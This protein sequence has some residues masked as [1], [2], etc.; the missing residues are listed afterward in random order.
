RVQ[1]E[2]FGGVGERVVRDQRSDVREFRLFGAEEFAASGRVEEEVADG[3]GGSGGETSLFDAEDVASG[4]L[5][6]SSG[7]IFGRASFQ[8]KA[9]DAGD[10]R[11]RLA[12]EAE[13][14]DGE[15]I[16]GGTELRGS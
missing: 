10:R 8:S 4:D 3:D 7:S 13:C 14:I 6:Q 5:D 1:L 15:Q 12:T 16:V 11:Q 9:G 2:V